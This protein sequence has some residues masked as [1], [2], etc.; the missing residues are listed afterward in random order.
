M[1]SAAAAIV[2]A[3]AAAAVLL[4]CMWHVACCAC[5]NIN[6]SWLLACQLS[7]EL[8]VTCTSMIRLGSHMAISALFVHLSSHAHTVQQATRRTYVHGAPHHYLYSV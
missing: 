2:V 8:L 6:R 5:A 3:A 1:V 7:N 4:E